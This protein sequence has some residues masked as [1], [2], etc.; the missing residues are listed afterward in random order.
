MVIG[1]KLWQQL[2]GLKTFSIE[3][4]KERLKKFEQNKE[5]DDAIA[6]MKA[7]IEQYP[8]DVDAAISMN[9]LIMHLLVEEDFDLKKHD[10]YA[11]LAK[12]YFDITYK[13]FSNNAQYLYYTAITAVMSEW[14][15]N[16]SVEDYQKMMANA[17]HLDPNNP[18]YTFMYYYELHK[19]D[20]NNKEAFEY[21]TMVLSKHSPVKKLLLSKGACG[22]YIFGLRK[23][24]SEAVVGIRPCYKH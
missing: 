22:E 4:W 5:W 12:K 23:H 10:Y 7:V 11:G 14:Y 24:W 21:A 1:K 8:N 9:Y 16:I 17:Q 2:I 19:K 18:V 6:L 3:N 13:R 20:H 15:Y